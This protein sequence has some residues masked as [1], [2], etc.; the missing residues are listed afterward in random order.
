MC[1]LLNTT[2]SNLLTLEALSVQLPLLDEAGKHLGLHEHLQEPPQALG[3]D[4]F[5][6]GLTQKGRGWGGGGRKR[7]AGWGGRKAGL[8]VPLCPSHEEW[9]VAH[10]LHE[11]THKGLWNHCAERAGVWKDESS[12]QGGDKLFTAECTHAEKS[13]A[14]KTRFSDQ[15]LYF[16]FYLCF[17]VFKIHSSMM[18]R[19]LKITVTPGR[20]AHSV[21]LQKIRSTVTPIPPLWGA[22]S[23]RNV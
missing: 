8:V 11:E 13:A 22:W 2:F 9:V 19:A 4:C 6:K 20:T 7:G 18:F 21:R 5:A 10:H 23:S 17:K 12:R 3:S 15:N 16:R 1:D 14:P